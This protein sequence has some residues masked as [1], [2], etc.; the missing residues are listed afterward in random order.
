MAK[1]PVKVINMS[2]DVCGADIEVS[3][4]GSPLSIKPV[5]CC[6]IE[7]VT[8]SPASQKKAASR[9]KTPAP[10]KQAAPKKAEAKAPAPAVKKAAA[11]KAAAKPAAKKPTKK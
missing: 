11:K 9:K 5:M 2:C 10:A 3:T 1:K 8:V 7:A 4:T 6:G